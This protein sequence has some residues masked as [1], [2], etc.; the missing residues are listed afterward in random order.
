MAMISKFL[1]GSNIVEF[2]N[3]GELW[4]QTGF[5][6]V[7]NLGSIQ[8]VYNCMQSILCTYMSF[9]F[10]SGEIAHSFID[11]ESMTSND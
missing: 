8:G 5:G 7:C 4:S 10:F 11:D 1:S 9:F 6:F 3:W 2:Y